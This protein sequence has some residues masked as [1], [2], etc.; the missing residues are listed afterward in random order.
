MP[1]LLSLITAALVLYA[2]VCLSLEGDWSL[3]AL[4]TANNLDIETSISEQIFRKQEIINKIEFKSC[5]SLV[6]QAN[7]VEDN[8]YINIET[9]R[10]QPLRQCTQEETIQMNLI[11][12]WIRGVLKFE[13]ADDKLIIMDPALDPVFQFQRSKNSTRDEWSRSIAGSWITYMY[14]DP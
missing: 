2:A 5:E 6:Y 1:N 11:K 14:N 12:R 13:I 7:V 10:Q 8:I 4:P 9:E 3:R